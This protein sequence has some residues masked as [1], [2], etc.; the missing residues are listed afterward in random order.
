MVSVI[1]L[2]HK[3]EAA[4]PDWLTDY[5]AP[6]L[7]QTLPQ[8]RIACGTNA[9]FAQLNGHFP[10]SGFIDQI[11][12]SVHP[13]EHASDNSTLVENLRAQSDSVLSARHY[14]GGKDILVSPVNIQRRFNANIENFETVKHHDSMP[15]QVDTRQM[16]L[17]CAGWTAGSLKYLGEAGVK[18]V[19]YFETAGERGIFQGDFN[20]RWPEEFKSV[21]GMIFPV[22]HLFH[23]LLKDKSFRIISSGSDHP[24]TGRLYLSLRWQKV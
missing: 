10:S 7:K 13:Q 15:S 4:T 9:N 6:R 12:Y 23:F 14:S 20:S 16:S 3:T 1:S 8:V 19:T 17:F 21:S 11:C 18:G 24:L 22:Y 5:V 2:F